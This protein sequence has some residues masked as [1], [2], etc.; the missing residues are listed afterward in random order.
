MCR[1]PFHEHV[2][3]STMEIVKKM[4]ANTWDGYANESSVHGLRFTS[5]GFSRTRRLSWAILIVTFFSILLGSF[6][7]TVVQYFQFEV[8]TVVTMVSEREVKFPAVTLCN[9]NTLRRSKFKEASKDAKYAQLLGL[10]KLLTMVEFEGK[11]NVSI[12]KVSGKSI[13]EMYR[14]FGHTMNPFEKGGMLLNCTFKKAP[15]NSSFFK[16]VLTN[17]GQCYTFNPGGKF[18]TDLN[19]EGVLTASQPG[20]GFGLAL[21]L[22]V[23]SDEY[24]LM[25]T[26]EFSVGW[27][28]LI[29]D[30]EELPLVADYGFALSPGTH[31]FSALVKRKV[32]SEAVSH[33]LYA[34]PSLDRLTWAS[35]DP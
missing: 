31:T 6:V 17:L 20:S 19:D 33:S 35:L 1:L 12:P 3:N 2:K 24:I 32:G 4:V 10:A 7:S 15:C 34:I 23:Q 26:Q 8:N 13:R 30:Q 25:P 14:Y 5:P 16:P 18:S 28:I 11:S 29:H 21:R 9:F 27:K 22:I